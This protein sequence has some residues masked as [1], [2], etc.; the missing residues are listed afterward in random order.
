MNRWINWEEII[1]LSFVFE[2][3]AVETI[4]IKKNF[5]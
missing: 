5:I 2:W 1:V 3:F 4:T